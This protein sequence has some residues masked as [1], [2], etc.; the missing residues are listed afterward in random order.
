MH[1]DEML[2]TESTVRGLLIRQFP[3]LADQPL[4][5]VA[6]SGTVNA[7]FRLGDDLAVR[8]PIIPGGAAGIEHE[9]AWLP[10]LADRLPVRIP[11]VLGVGVPDEAYPCPW[12]VLDWLPGECPVPGDEASGHLLAKDLADLVASLR[13]VD[14]T[15]APAGYRGGSLSDLGRPVRQSL[16]QVTDLVDV[17]TLTRLWDESVSAEPWPG[18]ATW[19]HCDLLSGNVLVDHGRLVGVLDF[20][21]SGVG[22]PACD[23]M[24]AWSIL[25]ASARALFRADVGLN[26]ATW[27]RGR[28][29]ALAQAVIALPYYRTTNHGMAAASLRALTALVLEA[30]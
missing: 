14:P 24:A 6:S 20:G 16:R 10:R 18:P 2:I 3:D 27:L 28:G 17:E 7:M 25:P 11:A 12:L 1:P 13:L 4:R 9:A 5:R 19:A 29:W 21:A 26:D 22:D 30:G 23:L 15:N 8:L